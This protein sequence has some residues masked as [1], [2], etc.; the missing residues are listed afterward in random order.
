[1]KNFSKS[2]FT[3]STIIFGLLLIPSFLAAWAEDEGTLGTNI[4]WTTF[5]KLFY[6]L[7]FPTHTLLWTSITKFG[8]TVHFLGLAINCAFYG[9][10]T[11][12]LIQ[13]YRQLKADNR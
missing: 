3:I 7:H 1:M 2:T 11:E 12:R 10:I 6:V 5:A 8:A 13:L 4:I 9:L